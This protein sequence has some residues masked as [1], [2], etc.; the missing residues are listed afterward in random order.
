[1][2]RYPRAFLPDIPPHIVQRGHD[3]QCVFVC[4]KINLPSFTGH[5]FRRKPDLRNS[6]RETYNDNFSIAI[7]IRRKCSVIAAF[8]QSIALSNDALLNFS[9][10]KIY[11]SPEQGHCVDST[12]IPKMA[13]GKC[14]GAG[15]YSPAQKNTQR[16]DR[17]AEK[18]T[19]KHTSGCL[20]DK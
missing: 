6:S 13:L 15:L 7:K 5:L 20:S 11:S 4:Q 8:S 17:H 3:R 1:M 9:P 2:P 14:Y 18:Q 16:R 19:G 12:R 10:A